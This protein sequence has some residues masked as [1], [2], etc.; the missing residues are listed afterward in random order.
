[1]SVLNL[2]AIHQTV[3]E[4][5]RCRAGGVAKKHPGKVLM[6]SSRHNKDPLQFPS[7]ITFGMHLHEHS[8]A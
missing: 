6:L 7:L 3:V 5:F 8:G 1:M 4:I 2:K